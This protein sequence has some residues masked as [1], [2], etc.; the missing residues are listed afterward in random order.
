MDRFSF[1]FSISDE[2]P[3]LAKWPFLVPQLKKKNSAN[4]RWQQEDNL[5]IMEIINDWAAN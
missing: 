5:F 3:L 1:L 4:A 2:G